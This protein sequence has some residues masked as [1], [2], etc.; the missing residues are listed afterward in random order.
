MLI[1]FTN[2]I[3][4]VM[5]TVSFTD[6]IFPTLD[7]CILVL[8]QLVKA[9][10]KSAEKPSSSQQTNINMLFWFYFAVF[11]LVNFILL[12]IAVADYFLTSTLANTLFF[13]FL[14]MWSSFEKSSILCTLKQSVCETITYPEFFFWTDWCGKKCQDTTT[15]CFPPSSWGV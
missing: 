10:P 3:S 13:S 14:S 8:I 2:N 11:E 1:T 4:I 15:K 12:Q 7:M 6:I 5:S 9:C